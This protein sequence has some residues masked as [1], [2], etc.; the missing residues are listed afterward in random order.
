MY[1]R[2]VVVNLIKL[3]VQLELTLIIDDN[4]N[5]IS[6]WFFTI[7]GNAKCEVKYFWHHY[8]IPVYTTYPLG[9]KSKIIST[10]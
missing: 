8:Y 1:M 9:P 2:L 7:D 6:E 10:I 5:W 3:P 4:Y